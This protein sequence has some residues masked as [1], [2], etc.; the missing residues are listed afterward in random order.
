MPKNFLAFFILCLN[1]SL[2]GSSNQL[3][4]SYQKIMD[5]L[6]VTSDNQQTAL[7]S[8]DYKI[9]VI[10]TLLNNGTIKVEIELWK[11]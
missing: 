5:I 8:D 7:E 1:L 11:K 2:Y 9:D 10:P 3:E 6:F 4:N